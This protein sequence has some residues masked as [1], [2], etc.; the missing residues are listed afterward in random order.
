M[1][2]THCHIDS[3]RFS[4]DRP[5]VLARAWAAGLKGIVVPAIGPEGWEALL[6]LPRSDARL[7]VGL[8]I[9]PQRLPELPESED[10]EHLERL[11]ALLASG[12][13]AVGECGLDGGSVAAGASLERQLRVLERHLDL[14]QKHGLPVLVHCLKAHPALVALLERRATPPAG[15]LLHSYSGGADLVPFYLRKGCD[16]SFAGPVTFEGARKPLGAARAVPIDRL[17]AETDAPDQSPHPHRGGR[18]EPGFLPLVIAALGEAHRLMP[19]ELAA[20]TA[21]NARRLFPALRAG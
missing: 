11:D 10:D 9:H 13:A 6:E 15:M 21:E 12:A 18:C 20:R 3:P 7:Q 4:E 14:A 19:E 8:G 5:E 2:D 16:F 1:I 17:H